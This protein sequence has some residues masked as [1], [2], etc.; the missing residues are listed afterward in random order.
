ML[1]GNTGN[2]GATSGDVPGSRESKLRNCGSATA[3]LVRRNV[4][5][6]AWRYLYNGEFPN[7]S[8]GPNVTGAWHGAEIAL[9]FGNTGVR[10]PDT[11]NE[12]KLIKKL[13][14]AWSGFAKDPRRGLSK[15]GWP[16][17]DES[18]KCASSSPYEPM[19]I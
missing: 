2:E 9:I 15:L 19:L 3:A 8:L 11:E 4:G 14:A 13:Q 7:Q 12:K 18:S 6:P 17:Y 16:L 1:V 10:G 5:V